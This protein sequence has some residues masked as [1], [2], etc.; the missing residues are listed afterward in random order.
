MALQLL[1]VKALDENGN[2]MFTA[3][4]IAELKNEVRDEDLQGM[5][6]ALLT[7]ENNVTEEEAKKLAECLRNDYPLDL[8]CVWQD[9]GYTL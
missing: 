8:Q 6:M 7:N 3:G 5:M 1:V 2:R 9:L 4:E